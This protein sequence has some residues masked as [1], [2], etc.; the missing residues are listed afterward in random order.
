MFTKKNRCKHFSTCQKVRAY[1]I[2]IAKRILP[3]YAY[4]RAKAHKCTFA[5]LYG[6]IGQNRRII[7]CKY[8]YMDNTQNTAKNSVYLRRIR[9]YFALWANVRQYIFSTL[10]RKLQSFGRL[11]LYLCVCLYIF[12]VFLCFMYRGGHPYRGHP[13]K[14]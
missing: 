6:N 9:F 3:V 2:Y 10:K 8:T 13:N 7:G 4:I 1:I 5:Y 14:V 11:V 12:C